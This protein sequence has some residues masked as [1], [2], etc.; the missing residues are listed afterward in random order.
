MKFSR[1]N[2]QVKKSPRGDFTAAI[3]LR[4]LRSHAAETLAEVII[5][6]TVITLGTGSAIILVNTSVN[7][8]GAGENRL[9]AYNLA[10]EGVE[11]VRN[12]RDTNLLRFPG[13]ADDCWDTYNLTDP[14]YCSIGNN[15]LGSASPGQNITVS[16]VLTGTADL[17]SWNVTPTPASTQLYTVDVNGAYSASDPTTLGGTFYTHDSASPAVASPFSRVINI[18]KTTGSG[19]APDEMIVAATVTWEEKGQPQNIQF[20]DR[21]INY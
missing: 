4:R 11:A 18:V 9:I 16:P 6:I 5:A 15:K 13:E 17:F 3:A 19:P 1:A 14:Q 10:R 2:V 12:I 20:V 8:T 7:A 21:L